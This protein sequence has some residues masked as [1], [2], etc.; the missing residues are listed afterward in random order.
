MNF[1]KLACQHTN[2]E[3]ESALTSAKKVMKS[4][5]S[6]VETTKNEVAVALEAAKKA[7]GNM[8]TK[9]TIEHQTKVTL[10]SKLKEK[11]A[12]A[13]EEVA[14]AE[15]KT[16]DAAKVISDSNDKYKILYQEVKK[17][18]EEQSYNETLTKGDVEQLNLGLKFYLGQDEFTKDIAKAID[19]FERSAK[20]GNVEATYQ[21]GE[22]YYLKKEYETAEEYLKFA[23]DKGHRD[24]QF[25]YGNLLAQ[26]GEENAR[27]YFLKAA[28]QGH[29]EAQYNYGKILDSEKEFGEA[30]YYFR[31]A[32]SQNFPEAKARLTEMKELEL[33]MTNLVFEIKFDL[34]IITNSIKELLDNITDIIK[35]DSRD[36]KT[37]GKPTPDSK[38]P[39]EVKA[40]SNES[41]V[42]DIAST[43]DSKDPQSQANPN[44]NDKKKE[45]N[46]LFNKFQADYTKY[47]QQYYDNSDFSQDDKFLD[48]INVYILLSCYVEA[49]KQSKTAYGPF[50]TSS[51]WFFDNDTFKIILADFDITEIMQ[52]YNSNEPSEVSA[53]NTPVGLK[54]AAVNAVLPENPTK[55]DCKTAKKLA[56][57]DRQFNQS[58]PDIAKE[59]F[60]QIDAICNPSEKKPVLLIKEHSEPEDFS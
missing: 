36:I 41:P 28:N 39:P 11:A 13:I 45:P 8:K 59:K 22:M 46:E 19:L 26:M 7:R 54:C 4:L 31:L 33:G 12:K 35:A 2:K 43:P 60:Q 37:G 44:P 49:Y 23:A 3:Q 51:W 40:S 53:I 32:A 9:R 47:M 34:T 50:D 6:L 30:A 27:Q 55:N 20:Q 48:F 5:E 56:H 42:V 52:K 38:D 58:C 15:K 17:L 14:D 25:Y 24:A 29:P 10:L 16:T 18:F 1:Y 21:L 57:P